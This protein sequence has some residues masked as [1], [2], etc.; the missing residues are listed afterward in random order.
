MAGIAAAAA[1]A[2]ILGLGGNILSDVGSYHSSSAMLEKQQNY[3]TNVVQA[4]NAEQAQL[5]RDFEKDM[6]STAYQRAVDDMKNAGLNPNLMYSNAYQASTPSASSA[7]N[8]FNNTSS[9]FRASNYGA[10]FQSAVESAVNSALNAN[11]NE[12]QKRLNSQLNK[13][14]KQLEG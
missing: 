7:S 4:F 5:Q 12:L 2:G 6:S 3:N 10:L 14:N 11:R 1:L 8:S 13:L 9:A